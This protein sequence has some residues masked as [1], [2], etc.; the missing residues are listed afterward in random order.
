VTW[1]RLDDLRAVNPKLCEIGFAARGLDEAAICWCSYKQTD[2]FIHKRDVVMLASLH[3]QEN[4]TALIRSLCLVGRWSRVPERG[5]YLIHDYLE[6]NPSRAQIQE[7]REQRAEAGRRGGLASGQARASANGSSASNPVPS[8]P[9]SNSSRGGK[10]V[11]RRSWPKLVTE[12]ADLKFESDYDAADTA[13]LRWPHD[14]DLRAQAVAAW[15][16]KRGEG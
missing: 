6:F 11:S 8:R 10:R 1:V 3:G 15:Q 4:V 13:M 12:F 5:G 9:L 16:A 7:R 2:G 14:P